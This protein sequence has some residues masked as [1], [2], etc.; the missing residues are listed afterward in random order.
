MREGYQGRI[1][2][3]DTKEGYQGRM[4]RKDGRKDKWQGRKEGHQGRK[5]IHQPNKNPEV[6]HGDV[7]AHRDR[8]N[9][10]GAQI[11][12]T[13]VVEVEGDGSDG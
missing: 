13:L 3:K 4:S 2:R 8:S 11:E 7:G 1:S 10:Q 9:S 5:D 12:Q 6:Q